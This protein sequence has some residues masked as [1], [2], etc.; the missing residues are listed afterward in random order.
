LQ[1]SPQ[2]EASQKRA[3]DRPA[4]GNDVP[5][6]N[7]LAVFDLDK[8]LL[9]NESRISTECA[10]RLNAAMTVGLACTVASGRD[11]DH[12][13]PYLKQMQWTS[14]PVIAE[15]GAVVIAPD[16]HAILM[17]RRIPYDVVVAALEAVCTSRISTAI[18]LFGGDTPQV[19][20]TP[21]AL[22]L[23]GGATHGST[24][25]EVRKLS[26][27]RIVRASHVRKLSL[28]C[29]REDTGTMR[30]LIAGA[31]GNRATVVKADVDFVNMMDAGVDKG[32]ALAWLLDYLGIDARY[33][34]AVGDCEADR[35]MFA[36]AGV[37][38]AVANA[39]E[40]TR[41]AARFIVPSNAECGAAVALLQFATGM[42]GV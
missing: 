21:G 36:L 12:I 28:R 9:N 30:S 1:K 32:S 11:M 35:S 3:A 24:A 34:M 7:Q 40:Q 37:S 31:L 27:F 41:L 4:V 17:E 39:D 29:F 10:D 25:I 38:V 13:D 2:T 8:T 16:T 42:Y 26:D 5:P 20:H 14:V 6:V 18:T 22:D 23:P 15:Q 19:F 33:V